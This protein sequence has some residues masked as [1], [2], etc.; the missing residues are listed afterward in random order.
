MD[1][2]KTFLDLRGEGDVCLRYDFYLSDYNILLEY[3]GSQ[4]FNPNTGFFT[5]RG[6]ELDK[7][8]Y[9]YAKNNNIPLLY[10]TNEVY[11]YNRFGYFTEV[12][13]D[14]NI[15]IEKIKEIGLTNQ[16]NS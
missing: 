12:I 8:K 13:T 3:H 14:A 9:N 2:E 7:I 15:L 16:S 4:H 10:F 11:C 1:K 5:D 6:I